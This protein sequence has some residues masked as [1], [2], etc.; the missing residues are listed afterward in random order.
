MAS[1]GASPRSPRGSKPKTRHEHKRQ[2]RKKE[3][4]EE[5]LNEKRMGSGEVGPLGTR[6]DDVENT[7]G[8]GMLLKMPETPPSPELATKGR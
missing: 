5:K 6:R 2:S 3:K 7:R 8:R 1:P 4:G